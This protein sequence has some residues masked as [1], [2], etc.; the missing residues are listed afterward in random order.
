MNCSRRDFEKNSALMKKLIEKQL[1]E[2]QKCYIIMYYRDQATMRDIAARYGVNPSTVSRTI[3]RGRQRLA[4]TL[5]L[6]T[7]GQ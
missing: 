4:N 3:K 1:T 5:S 6:I 7:G 2:R